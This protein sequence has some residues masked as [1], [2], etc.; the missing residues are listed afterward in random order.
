[1]AGLTPSPI[2]SIFR[3]EAEVS[4]GKSSLGGD[5]G[6]SPLCPQCGSDR[7]WCDGHR[8]RVS[9]DPIQRWRCK[10]C[11]FR[12]SDP[13]KV[14]ES[15]NRPEEIKRFSEMVLK[16]EA[17][18]QLYGQIC[19]EETKNLGSAEQQAV[20]AGD[21]NRSQMN[22]K[23]R[24][25]EFA[26]WMQKQGYDNATIYNRSYMLKRL[27]D[28]GADIESSE[29]VKE[30]IAVQ[31]TWSESYKALMVDAYSLFLTMLGRS[32]TPPRYRIISKMGFVPT[33]KELNDLI[34]ATSKAKSAFLQGLKDTGADP[35]ELGAI[36][37]IDINFDTHTV[38]L[39]NPVKGHNR[40]ILQ[41]T[42]QFLRKIS[43]LPR[44]EET[45]FNYTN[46]RVNFFKQRIV[47]ARKLANPRIMQISFTT[48]RRW[49]G[50]T[51]YHRTKDLLYVQRL[52]G[53]KKIDN[54]LIYIDYEKAAFGDGENDA[55]VS[56]VALNTKEACE[57]I[58][59]GFQYVTGE[60]HDGGKIFKKSRSLFDAG[61]N[62]YS[63][64]L[65]LLQPN[66]R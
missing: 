60:Y 54:T 20:S 26:F 57:L 58:E 23:S 44:K 56:R 52:L 29:S 42:D 59:A 9:G 4:D 19:V 11:W 47:I 48:F 17:D 1:M 38:A 15:K 18:Y 10:D 32:W 39:N 6:S 51:E 16:R 31:K 21:S 30:T 55:Y 36:R 5:V 65:T 45:V 24:A 46:I 34:A 3:P 13:D 64:K 63:G 33:E 12:F 53:H 8:Y 61:G 66:K 27:A 28:K 62:A 49:K 22:A 25:L 40:R 50:T 7:V 41:V 43:T 35:G 2:E 14:Q 37:W